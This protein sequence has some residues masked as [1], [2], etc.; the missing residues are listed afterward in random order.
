MQSYNK[1]AQALVIEGSTWEQKVALH[2][3]D[4]ESQLEQLAQSCKD[5]LLAE[6]SQRA[7]KAHEDKIKE[8]LHE[9]LDTLDSNMAVNLKDSYNE[10]VETYNENLQDILK[11]GFGMQ[12][13]EVFDFLSK[14]EK[15]AYD[16]CI[17]E[18]KSVFASSAPQ[19]LLRKFNTSFKKDE[20][21]KLHEWREIEES[22][23]KELFEE[24]KTIVDTVMEQFKRVYFPTGITKME[25]IKR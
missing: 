5:K 8:V 15:N 12:R 24:S 25:E 7:T 16:Y 6:V 10:Q 11:R 4:L 22:K 23:I 20:Q 14:S 13:E 9:A 2:T 1:K 3:I 17:K 19:S 21:G 18:L